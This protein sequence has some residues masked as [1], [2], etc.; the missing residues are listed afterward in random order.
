MKWVR[1]FFLSLRQALAQE[2]QETRA[3]LGAYQRYVL[4][5]GTPEEMERANQQFRNVVKSI[6]FGAWL[7]LPFS[8][9]TLP[10]VIQLSK[11]LGL[12]ILPS[13]FSLHKEEPR[14]KN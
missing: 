8:L 10:F 14:E 11:R 3:M 2:S 9:I 4:G 12:D 13:W 7:V 5:Q 6:G 1:S